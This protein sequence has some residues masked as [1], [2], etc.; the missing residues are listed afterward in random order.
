M[1]KLPKLLTNPPLVDAVF[2]VRFSGNPD[3]AEFFPG[4]LFSKY[5]SSARVT[6]LPLYGMPEEIRRNDRNL[7]YAPL[8]IVDLE[9]YAVSLSE[10][11]MVITAKLPYQGWDKFKIKISEI[12]N[13]VEKNDFVNQLERF[14]LKYTNVI[15][16]NGNEDDLA[17]TTAKIIIANEEITDGNIDVKVEKKIDNIIRIRRITSNVDVTIN[18][19][20]ERMN[21]LLVESDTIVNGTTDIRIDFNYIY[22]ELDNLKNTNKKDFFDI[23]TPSTINSLGPKYD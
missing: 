20:N 14:S 11:S 6:R 9:G 7:F 17:K 4:I 15:P 3:F 22:N 1:T 5:K 19:S 8:V 2:E 10:R 18:H 23:L 13:L 12:I 21:G 16:N